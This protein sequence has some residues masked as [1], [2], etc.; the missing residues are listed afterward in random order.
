M[1]F[2]KQIELN[3]KAF[4]FNAKTDYLP[5]YKSFSFN[6]DE[7]NNLLIKDILP[8]IKEQNFM[9]SYPDKDLLFRVNNLIVTGEEKLARVIEKL[10]TDLTI[11]PP[12]KYRSVNGLIID[13]HDFIH[14][15][16]R[17]FSCTYAK[18]ESLAYYIE[19]Y[20]QHY[21][22]ETFEYNKEYVGDAI[23]ILAKKM[24]E[25]NSQCKDEVLEAI[26]DEFNGINQCE[27][28]NN[29]FDGKDYSEDI[30]WL[31]EELK[32]YQMLKDGSRSNCHKL[33]SYCRKRARKNMKVDSLSG[34]NI[35]FYVGYNNPN[36]DCLAQ[37]YSTIEKI[38]NYI[39]VTMSEK[40]AGQTLIDRSQSLA[41]KKAGKLMLEALDEGAEVLLFDRDE[42][43]KLFGSI[44]ADVEREVGRPIS[45]S[46][47]SMGEFK[48][49]S[50]RS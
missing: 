24:I 26:N 4:F 3:V 21:A 37:T 27:Y 38:G 20:P 2:K 41:Y 35:A 28:E 11:D 43:Y 29:V 39:P 46:L 25:D 50:A 32:K 49:L 18:K 45:L 9:F 48:E 36:R 10:G 19:L 31:R 23:L 47:L 5:Y 34:K 30:E 6:I 44:M 12:S 8:M 17:I 22:S 7:D 33:R 40:S 16:R 42:D 15:Y 1:R 14:K 13:N